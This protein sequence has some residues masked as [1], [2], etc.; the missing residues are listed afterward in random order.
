MGVPTPEVGYTSA[1]PRREEH[2]VHND[3]WGIG[4]KKNK[5][6]GVKY[7]ISRHVVTIYIFGNVKG[8]ELRSILC[9]AV[10]ASLPVPGKI[11]LVILTIMTNA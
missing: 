7:R 6:K 10:R 5:I 1:M 2:E 3:M 8:N 11:S 4:V 9:L